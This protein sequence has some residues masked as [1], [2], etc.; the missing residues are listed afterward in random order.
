MIGID[1]NAASSGST[2]CRGITDGEGPR[3]CRHRVPGGRPGPQSAVTAAG[4]REQILA[5]CFGS[6]FTASAMPARDFAHTPIANMMAPAGD[7]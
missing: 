7:G 4:R 6:F 2:A 3:A 5:A 1:R